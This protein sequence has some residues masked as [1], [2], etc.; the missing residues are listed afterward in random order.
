MTK[1]LNCSLEVSAFEHQL[2]Y[3]VYFQTNTPGKG[4]NPL[5]TLAM[6]YI[7]PLLF[8]NKNDLCMKVD[9]PFNN[10]NKGM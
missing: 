2:H 6:G 10:E 4:V 1:V 9:M 7:G 3:S 8:F 5:I